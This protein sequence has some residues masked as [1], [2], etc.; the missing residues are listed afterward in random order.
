MV[1]RRGRYGA[2]GGAE[3]S[4]G[5]DGRWGAAVFAGSE[6]PSTFLRRIPRDPES[7]PMSLDGQNHHAQGS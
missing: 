2:G 1:S 4:L 5:P 6:K 7:V 3:G